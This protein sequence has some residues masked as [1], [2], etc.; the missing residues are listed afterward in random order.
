[1][2]KLK[3]LLI[4]L[5]VIAVCLSV[6]AVSAA[7]AEPIVYGAATVDA[8]YLNI[9]SGPGMSYSVIGSV[10]DG[11]IVVI[12]ERTSDAWYE[13]CYDG[14]VGYVSTDFLVDV[15]TAEDFEGYGRVCGD[16]VRYRALP[17]PTGSIL[18]ELNT[19]DIVDIL[20]V[21]NGWYKVEV[22][23]V[24]GY[25]RS[26]YIKLVSERS[27]NIV[28]PIVNGEPS[29]LGSEI[30]QFALQFVGYPYVY[31]EESPAYGFDC[32][33]LVYYVFGDV[34]GYDVCRTS[35]EQYDYDG[36]YV[37]KAD[38]QPGDLVF[39]STNGGAY[40]THV[41]IYIG[42]SEFVHASNER[43]GVTVSSLNSD[44]YTTYWYGAKRVAFDAA[45]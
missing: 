43:V 41:G 6:L 27:V 21:N 42:D 35:S 33:G 14:T 7:A 18:G 4:M 34:F 10:S 29:K 26:D 32:S 44:Y 3:R 20:G 30:A 12:I 24:I 36:V 16:Y 37:R 5:L 40:A 2:K 13:I 22:N 28:M 9:R 25:M 1:M 17:G 39:F 31:G 8:D 45:E 23:G 15:Y 19:G 11:K 38:L